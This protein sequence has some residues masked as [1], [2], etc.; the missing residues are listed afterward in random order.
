MNKHTICG[1][2]GGDP[3]MNTNGTVCNFTVATD[4]WVKNGEEFEK[5]T[6]WH[7]CVA[8]GK[9]A[10]NI[11]KFFGKG[12]FILLEGSVQTRKWTNKEGAD[13]YTTEHKV[14]KFYF[15]S[16]ASGTAPTKAESP[17]KAP[18]QVLGDDDAPF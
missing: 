17:G 5:G 8:F 9:N 11:V 15:C 3:E 4:K 2:L 10:E 13:Q 14:D 7:R 16:D 12:K 6:D 1:R 18:S